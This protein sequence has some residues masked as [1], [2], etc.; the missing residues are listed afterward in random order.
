DVCSSDLLE[1]DIFSPASI[2]VVSPLDLIVSNPP[3]IGPN[4]KE[5]LEPQV[6]DFEPYQALFTDDLNKMYGSI[7][8]FAQQYL[9]ENG[10]LYLELHEHFA[11]KIQDIFEQK[12]WETVVLQDYDN[13]DRFL[14][15]CPQ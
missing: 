10:S 4:E 13:N 7:E 6:R 11:N 15:A 3:Y 8:Q 5:T 12:Y 14:I 2:E 1:G 9:A